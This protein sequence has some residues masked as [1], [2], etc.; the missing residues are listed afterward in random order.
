MDITGMCRSSAV[1]VWYHKPYTWASHDPYI[2]VKVHGCLIMHPTLWSLD[3]PGAFLA[4]CINFCEHMLS[5]AWFCHF[6]R[7]FQ[8]Y[9]P[10]CTWHII[11]DSWYCATFVSGMLLFTFTFFSMLRLMGYCVYKYAMLGLQLHVLYS[12]T[13]LTAMLYL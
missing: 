6:Q 10:S 11:P 9:W 1:Q 13:A 2:H 4:Q 5:A 8:W 7:Y 12:Y 3:L